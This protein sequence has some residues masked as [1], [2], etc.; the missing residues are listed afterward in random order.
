M[1]FRL[2]APDADTELRLRHARAFLE[3]GGAVEIRVER[4]TGAREFLARIVERLA[5]VGAAKRNTSYTRHEVVQIIESCA[6][7]KDKE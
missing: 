6:S 7:V 3:S 5:D 1:T 2:A 4:T